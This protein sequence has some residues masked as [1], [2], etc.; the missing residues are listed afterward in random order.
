MLQKKIT[1]PL[2]DA[3]ID[4]LKAGD[5]VLL[6]GT[7]FTARDAAH[8]RMIE[9]E[10]EGI[11]FPIDVEG[12][13]IYYTGPTPAKPGEVIG[14]AGPTTSGRMDLYTPRLLEKGLKGMIGKGYRNEEVKAAIKQHRAVYFGAV[15]GAAALIARSIKSVEVIAYEDL[16]TEAI[17]KLTIEN[18]PVFVVNDAHGGDIYQEGV[19]QFRQEQ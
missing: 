1:L 12:Q 17:R 11:P 3:D 5:R 7:V 10:K 18:F 2:T 16:G 13:V 8:K 14:S 19:A 15:G 6:S 4:S 9:Q